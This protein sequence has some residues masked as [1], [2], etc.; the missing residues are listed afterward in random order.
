[1]TDTQPENETNKPTEADAQ[2]TQPPNAPPTDAPTDPPALSAEQQVTVLN[3]QILRLLAELENSRRR[4]ERDKA[5]ALKYGAMALARDI[6]GAVDDLQRALKAINEVPE[7]AR[8][9][10]LN[11]LQE[12][13]AATERNLL[14]GLSRHKVA[15]I[16]PMGEKFDPN[17]HEALFEAPNSGQPSGTI[18]EVVEIGYMM[19]ERLLR[20]AKVGVAKAKE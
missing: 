11:M 7:A 1:M 5:D 20:P 2:D 18:I 9:D 4:A 17:L 13:V 8:G 10:T 12:G 19:D 16:N 3:E 15:P 14:S 6:V